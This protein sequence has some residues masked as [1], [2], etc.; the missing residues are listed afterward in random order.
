MPARKPQDLITRSETKATKRRRAANETSLT[1]KNPLTVVPP[2]QLTGDV[3]R[4]TWQETVTLYFALDAR[5][6]SI[7]DRG[8]LLDYCTTTQQLAEIDELRR[9]AMQNY[10]KANGA[11]DK[12]HEKETDAKGMAKLIA[13]VN[14]SLDEIIKLDGRADRKR[15]LLHT[16]R[17]SLY[18]TPRSRAG[19][20]PP[21]KPPEKPRS[22]MAEIID[23]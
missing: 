3:A 12:A 21:E 15:A 23:G 9:Q 17:Q 8:L 1:P 18:L 5:I 14:W 19:V 20:A 2:P 13:A 10:I 7:L 11:L 4:D 6:V 22:R 16:M